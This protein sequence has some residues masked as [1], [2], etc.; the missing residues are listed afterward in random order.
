MRR[1]NLP[2]PKAERKHPILRN[3]IRWALYLL[4]IFGAFIFANSGDFLKPLLLIPIALGI[5]SVSGSITA[6]IIGLVCGFLMDISSGTLLGYRAL[7]LF[8]ICI[9]ASILYDRLF[10]LHFLNTLLF[11][12]VTAFLVT[13]LDYIFRYWIWGYD[14]VSYL[15]T[16]Y[17]LRILL[18]T[19]A[20][21]IVFHLIF[22]LIHRFLL[23]ERKRTLER[24]VKPILEN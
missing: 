18:Y 15:Y 1:N 3:G 9:A 22:A 13:G 2:F 17:S 16:H 19:T 14:H 6:G 10:R 20:S 24:T 12:A 8:L 11:T 5:S 21:A 7:V 4:L 23:P